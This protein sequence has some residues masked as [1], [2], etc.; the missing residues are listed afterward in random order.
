MKPLKKRRAEVIAWNPSLS[1][2][3]FRAQ[4]LVPTAFQFY[5]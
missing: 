4:F 5:A 3:P 1:E 2:E